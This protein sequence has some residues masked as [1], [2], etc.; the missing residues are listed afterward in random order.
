MHN[1]HSTVND[2]KR[3]DDE[4]IKLRTAPTII[5]PPADDTITKLQT[6]I[7]TTRKDINGKK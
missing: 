2:V 6:N 3:A 1:H 7:P 4:A 5:I